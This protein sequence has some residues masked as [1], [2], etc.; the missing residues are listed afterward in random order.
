M[1]DCTKDLVDNHGAAAIFLGT[2]R[3]DPYSADLG[4]FAESSNGWPKF[5]RV[6]PILD[7]L[8]SH[9]WQFMGE[10]EVPYCKLYDLGYTYL[11]DKFDSVPN[12]FS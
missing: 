4:Y 5:V 10:F 11:G 7:F 3:T 9:I 2:R 6:L 12:P 1:L 8:Y